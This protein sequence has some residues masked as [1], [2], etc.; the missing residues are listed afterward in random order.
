[1]HKCGELRD[2]IGHRI[3]IWSILRNVVELNKRKCYLIV[4]KM[5]YFW[6]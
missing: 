5:H 4:D 2:E 6:L 3:S 1:M